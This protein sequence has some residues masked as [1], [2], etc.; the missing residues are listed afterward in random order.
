MKLHT[1]QF[2][3]AIKKFGRQLDSKITY[4]Q[5]DETIELGGEQLN[6]VSP[7][8]QGAILKSVMKELH[9]DSNVEIPLG[10]NLTYE[11]GVL[12]DGGYEYLNFGNYIVYSAE[13]K[14]DTR[15][16]EI[17]CYDKML[18]SMKTYEQ[19][20][21]GTFPMTVKDY[22]NNICLD[23]GIEFANYDDNF[24]N[25]SGVINDDLYKELGYTYRDVLDELSQVTAST[26][27]INKDDELEIRYINE[28]NDIIDEEYLKN[29]NV[30]F[31]EVC[32]PIN[33]IVLSR[34][35]ESDNVYIQDEES[36]EANGLH[37]IKIKDNQIMNFNDRSDYLQELLEKLN[38]LKFYV[39]D[40]SSTGVCYYELCDKYKISIGNTEYDCIMLNDEINITQGL[41]ENIHTELLEQSETDYTKADKT[42]RRINQAYIIVD[43]QKQRIDAV[44]SKTE[45]IEQTENNNYQELLDKFQSIDINVNKIEEIERSV[46][47]LQTD[48]Y[49][50]TEVNQIA[51]GIGVDGQRVTAVITTSATFDENGM[52]YEKSGAKTKTLINEVGVNVQNSDNNSLLFAGYV[53]E[54]NQDYKLRYQGQTIVGTDNVIVRNYLNV[55]PHC[56][57]QEYENGTG[58]FYMGGN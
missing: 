7:V 21:H 47:Q 27:C 57:I 19:L 22:I 6:S 46:T 8:Y 1:P 18:Y 20:Q 49:T 10:T 48:T 51:N 32:G 5:D 4:I 11:F 30:N 58:F 23:L 33:S 56:R 29:I 25:A 35:E 43:K 52:T 54:N 28:T 37:E 31:G 50:K 36:I 2:K 3:E 44:V 9:I 15:S 40:F 42:D 41:E 17:T 39:N 24:A 13:K 45:E 26:I 14:E 16:Y 34:A 55:E 12:T 53:D 38:G